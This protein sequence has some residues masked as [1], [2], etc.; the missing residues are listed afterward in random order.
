MPHGVDISFCFSSDAPT[1]SLSIVQTILWYYQAVGLETSHN[2]NVEAVTHI[3]A[4]IV[5][6]CVCNELTYVER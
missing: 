4:H 5:S 1:E 2:C 6:T 3:G